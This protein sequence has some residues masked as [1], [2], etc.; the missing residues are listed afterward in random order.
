MVHKQIERRGV[1]DPLTLNAMRLVKRHLF[2]PES[3]KYRAYSDRPLP[4]GHGQT[5][6][7]PYIVAFMTEALDLNPHAK[8]LE[9]GI[10]KSEIIIV[11][12]IISS[13]FIMNVLYVSRPGRDQLNSLDYSPYCSGSGENKGWRNN[14]Y[15]SKPTKF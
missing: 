8:V 6:S 3:E 13:R 10:G 14:H 4:I 5:I 15:F 9:I 7:Q 1:S 2:V 12:F 11:S